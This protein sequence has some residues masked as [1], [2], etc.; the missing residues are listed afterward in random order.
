MNKKYERNFIIDR[1]E[2]VIRASGYHNTGVNDILLACEIPKGSFYNFFD[3][4]EGF[5]IQVIRFYSDK[6]RKLLSVFFDNKEI[7]PIKRFEGYYASI[8]QINR[9]EGFS[10]GCLVN[11]LSLELG[12]LNK[13]IAAVLSNEY[14]SW[15]HI[16]AGTIKEGQDTL[17][18][19][20]EY[21]PQELADLLQTN[22]YG[23]LSRMKMMKNGDILEKIIKLNLQQL[24]Y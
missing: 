16:M 6:M 18:I 22:I 7:R 9:N 1:G 17:E 3:S 19:K 14:N 13:D 21:T 24:E 10:R 2:R 5:C 15:I 11:N 8:L 4:K 23:A 20:K 12:G